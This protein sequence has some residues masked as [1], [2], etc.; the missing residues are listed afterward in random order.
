MLEQISLKIANNWSDKRIIPEE[1]TDIYRYGIEI[2]LSTIVNILCLLI[3]TL[4]FFNIFDLIVFASF[5]VILRQFTGGYH[6]D[7]YVKCNL[8]TVSCYSLSTLLANYIC[9]DVRAI[10]VLFAA[11]LVLISITAPINN[12]NKTITKAQAGRYKA[13]AIIIFVLETA[14]TCAMLFLNS[15]YASNAFFTILCIIILM[16]IGMILNKRKENA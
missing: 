12:C 2:G 15:D 9:I 6:A 16:P 5:F 1:D 13:M 14:F 3:T 7:T 10:S 11:G 4:L 8:V